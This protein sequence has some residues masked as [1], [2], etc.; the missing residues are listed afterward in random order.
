MNFLFAWRYFKA[1]KTTNAINIISW[2]SMVAIMVGTAALILVLSVFNG[3][4]GLVK[5]LYSSFYPDLK[6]VPATGKQLTLTPEQLQKLRTVNGVRAVSL[7][8]EEKALLLNGEAQSN[9]YIKGVDSNYTAVTGVANHIIRGVF[10][11]GDAEQP[12]LVL[13]GG[14]ENALAVQ[15]DRSIDPITIY[16]GRLGSVDVQDPMK[17]VSRG[18]VYAAG[19]FVIQQD[20]DN[21][22]VLSNIAFVKSLLGLGENNYSAAEI[23]IAAGADV[24]AVQKAI[25]ALLNDTYTV[26]TRYE[27]NQ[28]LYSVMQTEKWFI[29]AILSLILVVAAFNMIGALTMLVLEKRADISVL[30]AL[31]GTR[32]FIQKIFLSEGLLLALLGGGGGMLLA[33]G[34]AL[35]QQKFHIFSLQGTSFLIDYFPVILN[36]ADFI[37][38]GVTVVVIAFIASWIPARKAAQQQFLLRSE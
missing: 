5:S 12:K 26:Q 13:G 24:E 20:F 6:L 29:Y 35:L 31:G 9:A 22:Y 15:S 28:S 33:L 2:I 36:A 17:S 16:T 11:V 32:A 18:D 23:A 27:Q 10:D 7:V 3:F 8:V 30:H 1:K 21:K 25:V 38:V 4:E 37:L 34:I 19:A 14:I